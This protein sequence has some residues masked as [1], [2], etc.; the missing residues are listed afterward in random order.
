MTSETTYFNFVSLKFQCFQSAV[1]KFKSIV[2]DE[3]NRLRCQE[4]LM[5]ATDTL[6]LVRIIKKK[7]KK[8][9]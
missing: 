6:E 9:K 5:R 7:N 8:N 3:L 1:F 2:G 4:V